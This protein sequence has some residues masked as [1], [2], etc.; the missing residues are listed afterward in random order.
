VVDGKT[1]HEGVYA[2]KWSKEGY[3]RFTTLEGMKE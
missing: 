3:Y 2:K 1:I